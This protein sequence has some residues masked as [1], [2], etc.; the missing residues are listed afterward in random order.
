M[1]Q[2]VIL[3]PPAHTP[4]RLERTRDALLQIHAQNSTSPRLRLGKR[5]AA[6]HA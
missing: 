1:R 4:G 2:S 3:E 6:A 5:R